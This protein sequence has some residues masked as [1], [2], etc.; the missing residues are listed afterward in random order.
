MRQE[1]V[2]EVMLSAPETPSTPARKLAV[3]YCVALGQCICQF[4]A[5]D[6]VLDSYY[7]IYKLHYKLHYGGPEGV[8][9]SDTEALS[10]FEKAVCRLVVGHRQAPGL[11][12]RLCEVPDL[13]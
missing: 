13:Q 6:W 7:V 9:S 8:L 11:L 4:L 5:G 12:A 1:A 2:S 10:V 3:D